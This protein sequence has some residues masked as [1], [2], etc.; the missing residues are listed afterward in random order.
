MVYTTSLC[1]LRC[2]YCGGSWPA[3]LLPPKPI[4]SVEEL[5][6]YISFD[7]DPTIVFY[8]GEPLLNVKFIKEVMD[9][10][11]ARYGIQTNATLHERLEDEYWKRFYAVLI[12]VDGPKEV[13]EKNRGK[14]VY[15]KAIELLERVKGLGVRRI[16]ARMAVGEWS[17]IYRDV[18][19][20]LERFPYVHWQLSVDWV[21]KWDFLG[22]A[23]RSYLPGIRK[24]AREFA[25]AYEEG[26]ILGIIPFIAILRGLA[27]P[28]EGVPCGAG[29]KAFSILTDGRVVHCPIA[30]YEGWAK[31]GDIIKGEKLRTLKVRCKC[32]YK[33]ICGGR[34]LYVYMERNW[35][36]EGF[37]EICYVT[38]KTIEILL[39]E[40]EPYLDSLIKEKEILEYDPTKDSTEGI[41]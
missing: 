5:K 13:T 41:P 40:L 14:G 24:L 20:L 6:R 19:H 15:D 38:Q 2:K 34:C 11:E 8:G 4:Y 22:W 28:Y 26:E 18:T 7:P 17:D 29:Y 1:N 35:G 37:K 12:S 3:K 39:E 16:I 33:G 23:K 9:N 32:P 36:E 31:A 27:K 25:K 30:V 10:V 21:D